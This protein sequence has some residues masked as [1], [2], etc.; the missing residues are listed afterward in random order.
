MIVRFLFL[1]LGF[2]LYKNVNGHLEMTDGSPALVNWAERLFGISRHMDLSQSLSVKE[3][4]DMAGK[5]ADFQNRLK[6]AKS[7]LMMNQLQ[8]SRGIITE[9]LQQESSYFSAWFL[10]GVI[11]YK[12]R[13]WMEA[14]SAFGRA[15][16]LNPEDSPTQLNLGRAYIE[17]NAFLMAEQ[18]LKGLIAREPENTNALRVLG[19]CYLEDKE[20]LL[21]IDM[22]KKVISISPKNIE[23]FHMIATAYSELGEVDVAFKY[24]STALEFALSGPKHVSKLPAIVGQI[25]SLP[26]S[27]D[28]KKIDNALS[29][30]ERPSTLLSLRERE[31]LLFAKA[32]VLERRAK[33]SEAWK[34][35]SE[36]NAG[37]VKRL[38][39]QASSLNDQLSR[40][41]DFAKI[42]ANDTEFQSL[43]KEKNAP[44]VL[45][46]VGASRSGKTTLERLLGATSSV[47]R[48]YESRI[49]ERAV[50]KTSLQLGLPKF[51]D[52]WFLPDKSYDLFADIF[53]ENLKRRVGARKIFTITYPGSIHH[54]GRLARVVPNSYF[55]FMGRDRNDQTLRCFQKNYKNGN[56]YSYDWNTCR[57]YLQK[58]EELSM[59]WLTQLKS[60]S[61]HL[62]YED[63]VERPVECLRRIE[64]LLG[65]SIEKDLIPKTGDD[66]ECFLSYSPFVEGD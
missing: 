4:A 44:L 49:V 11:S 48:G 14:A 21:A 33:Y 41:L 43:P 2:Q 29:K 19:K 65:V 64:G 42:S 58:Y 39:H 31:A 50:V 57:S 20:H 60:R 24:Y 28:L 9:I 5:L 15:A 47:E 22:L 27:I 38:D 18:T 45:F 35:F 32:R 13:K 7:L 62:L 30:V 16:M 52:F 36:V 56:N 55:V 10:L 6:T 61:L 66:R 23:T 51:S 12:E 26:V 3:L 17:N 8:K 40:S 1:K 54:A 63:L 53:S 25:L 46:I 37:I 34:V 59:Q